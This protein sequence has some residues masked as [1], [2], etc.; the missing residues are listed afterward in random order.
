M[1]TVFGLIANRYCIIESTSN[2]TNVPYGNRTK[3]PCFAALRRSS[4][5][6]SFIF[7]RAKQWYCFWKTDFQI[8]YHINRTRTVRIGE[9][10]GIFLFWASPK[11]NRN[12]GK[13]KLKQDSLLYKKKKEKIHP[14]QKQRVEVI[15]RK[16]RIPTV[17]EGARVKIYTALAP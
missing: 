8:I 1:L 17:F 16:E 5:I 13:S 14:L 11:F 3:R 15:P 7:T 10:G 6:F 9:G 12:I 2:I 4:S